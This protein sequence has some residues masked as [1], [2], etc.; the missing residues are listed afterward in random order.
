MSN[1]KVVRY[2][3]QLSFK[4]LEAKHDLSYVKIVNQ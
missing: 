3:S 1:K 4:N 2:I